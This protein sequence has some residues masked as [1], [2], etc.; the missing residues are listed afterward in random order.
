MVS[1]SLQNRHYAYSHPV[2]TTRAASRARR[3]LVIA[4]PAHQPADQSGSRVRRD[5]CDRL[6]AN[7]GRRAIDM[8]PGLP[9]H[10]AGGTSALAAYAAKRIEHSASL[11]PHAGH[12]PGLA[13]AI[14]GRSGGTAPTRFSAPTRPGRILPSWSCEFDSR[15]PLT[16]K[17]Q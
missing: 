6:C 13:T 14:T 10:G 12:K 11:G 8:T 17:A 15:H 7:H 16:A 3:L 1:P 2:Y 9:S 5:S 4:T